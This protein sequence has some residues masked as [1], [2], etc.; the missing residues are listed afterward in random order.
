[1]KILVEKEAFNSPLSVDVNGKQLIFTIRP[2][3]TKYAPGTLFLVILTKLP[4]ITF[5]GPNPA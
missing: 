1:M 5:N 2:V 3:W 4:A